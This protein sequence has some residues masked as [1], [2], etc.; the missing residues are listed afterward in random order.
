[1]HA[2]RSAANR[3]PAAGHYAE[4]PIMCVSGLMAFRLRLRPD[5]RVRVRLSG[6]P[7]GADRT[8]AQLP[9]LLTAYL[10][11]AMPGVDIL[12]CREEGSSSTASTQNRSICV[13]A[14]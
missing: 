11:I 1:M 4:N 14:I 6:P 12:I 5:R 10:Y 13:V 8:V 7:R 2:R 3:E 9:A